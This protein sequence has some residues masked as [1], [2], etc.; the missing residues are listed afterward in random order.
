ME[1]RTT[2]EVQL[3]MEE[4]PEILDITDTIS[5]MKITD[6]KQSRN[7]KDEAVNIYKSEYLNIS[8]GGEAANI[9]QS[10]NLD[11][12]EEMSG[13]DQD[14]DQA[15]PAYIPRIGQFFM[16]DTRETGEKTTLYP[17][18]R[19]DCKWRHDLYNETDQIPLSD[20]EFAKK[21]GV[22]REGNPVS[23]ELFSASQRDKRSTKQIRSWTPTNATRRSTKTHRIHGHGSD[24]KYKKKSLEK[25]RS[26]SRLLATGKTTDYSD[27]K[28]QELIEG[29]EAE[30][31]SDTNSADQSNAKSKIRLGKRYSTQRPI[32]SVEK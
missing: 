11:D 21:Y 20:R 2:V 22:D 27:W 10:K 15:H 18:S 29:K 7:L 16:H 25:R 23:S 17:L 31:K 30:R 28:N 26:D 19:A 4:D 1:T 9:E 24:D 6:D 3:V 5:E 13:P 12:D 32:K 14:Q 8:P